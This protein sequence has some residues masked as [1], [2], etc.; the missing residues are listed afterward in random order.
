MGEQTT[1]A[2]RHSSPRNAKPPNQTRDP[3][4]PGQRVP[5]IHATHETQALHRLPQPNKN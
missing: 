2:S 4:Q 1:V 3:V 5:P